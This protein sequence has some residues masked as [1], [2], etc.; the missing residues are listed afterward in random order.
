MPDRQSKVAPLALLKGILK[1]Q[2]RIKAEQESMQREF[3][4]R[5]KVWRGKRTREKPGRP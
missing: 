4:R 1:E 2:K 3:D 5:W